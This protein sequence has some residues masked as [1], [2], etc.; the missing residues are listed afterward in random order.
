[1]SYLAA[2]RYGL[3]PVP[4]TRCIQMHTK[5]G[6]GGGDRPETIPAWIISPGEHFA[7]RE[8]PRAPS[9]VRP[10]QL[11]QN[12]QDMHQTKTPKFRHIATTLSQNCVVGL[13]TAAAGSTA[14]DFMHLHNKRFGSGTFVGTLGFSEKTQ[15]LQLWP[16][17]ELLRQNLAGESFAT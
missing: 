12:T 2:L 13:H 1:M 16:S 8:I 9:V 7:T 14:P 15:S 10:T 11:Q 5:A 4:L 3:L 6:G 17:M